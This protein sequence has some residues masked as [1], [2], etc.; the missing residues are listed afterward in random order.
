[1]HFS[2]GNIKGI[3]SSKLYQ[4]LSL[5]KPILLVSNTNDVMEKIIDETNTGEICKTPQQ[6]ANY[7]FKSFSKWGNNENLER[8]VNKE[9]LESYSFKKQVDLLD[10][11]ISDL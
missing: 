3:P 2:Y 6:I 4:Y 7:I 8:E 9:K 5:N 10:K 11:I 1:V